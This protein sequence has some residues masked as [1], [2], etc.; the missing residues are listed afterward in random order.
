MIFAIM[1]KKSS[2]TLVPDLNA[3]KN[4]SYSDVQ[5]NNGL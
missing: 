4:L 5:K 1:C 3:E 2:G